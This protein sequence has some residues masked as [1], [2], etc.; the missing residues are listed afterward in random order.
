MISQTPEAALQTQPEN[1]PAKE[2]YLTAEL[3]DFDREFAVKNNM[4]WEMPMNIL[5]KK[6]VKSLEVLR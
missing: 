1:A 2:G 5:L 3:A 6:K 4:F